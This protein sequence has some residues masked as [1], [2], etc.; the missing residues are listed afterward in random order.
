VWLF[1]T[2]PPEFLSHVPNHR[3]AESKSFVIAPPVGN[4]R[5][6]TRLPAPL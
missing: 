6:V 5:F 3:P 2:V 1:W 4:A